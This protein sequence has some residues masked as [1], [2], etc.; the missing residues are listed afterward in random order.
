VSAEPLVLPRRIERWLQAAY[1]GHR[2]Q[3]NEPALRGHACEVKARAFPQFSAPLEFIFLNSRRRSC[4]QAMDGGAGFIVIDQGQSALLAIE[5]LL[6]LGDRFTAQDGLVVLQIPF[7]EAFDHNGEKERALMCVLR[8]LAQGP[9]LANLLRATFGRPGHS[10]LGTFLLLHE[11]AHFAVDSEQAFAAPVRKMVNGALEEHCDTNLRYSGLIERGEPLPA[12]AETSVQDRSPEARALMARQ[13]RDHIGFVGENREVVREASCDFLAT[14]GMLTWQ[15]G[16]DV[17]EAE[18]PRVDALTPRN[19]GD[20][21]A[22]GLRVSRLLMM[23]HFVGLSAENIAEER[24]PSRLSKAFSEM[25]ARHNVSVN[26]AVGLFEGIME[27]WRFAEPVDAV[28]YMKAFRRDI[29]I[30]NARSADRLLT[31]VEE[32]GLD[33]RESDRHEHD[34]KCLRAEFFKGEAPG[35]Q[36][37]RETLDAHLAK[38]PL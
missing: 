26:L 19:V 37:L 21:I 31:P 38:L 27:S 29:E 9:R 12:D 8:C 16:I 1:P 32:I 22:L 30:M 23:H 6:V 28:E 4:R 18:T 2:R 14:A 13:M 34:L 11:I 36:E 10:M 33:H 35:P 15:S 24:D 20:V 25:T 7:A 5:D 3:P 17:L